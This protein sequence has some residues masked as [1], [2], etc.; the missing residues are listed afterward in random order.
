[1]GLFRSGQG[2]PVVR[3]GKNHGR[4]NFQCCSRYIVAVPPGWGNSAGDLESGAAN[5]IVRN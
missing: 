3:S 2:L 1:M 4:F 5:T